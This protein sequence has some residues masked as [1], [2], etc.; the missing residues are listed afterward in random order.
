MCE[1]FARRI[2]FEAWRTDY[3][4][5]RLYSSIQHSIIVDRT[6]AGG[7]L[8]ATAM[9]YS[10]VIKTPGET[11][12]RDEMVESEVMERFAARKTSN[13]RAMACDSGAES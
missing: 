7:R 10:E 6:S 11:A 8:Y 1:L 9:C 3:V 2:A 13:H 5:L 4:S 12:L